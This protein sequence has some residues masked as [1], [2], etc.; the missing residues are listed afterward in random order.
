MV[1]SSMAADGA[2]AD[3]RRL[4]EWFETAPD[5]PSPRIERLT[6]RL[7]ALAVPLLGR[8][9]RGTD[10]RR[11]DAARD[12]LASL[13]R[14]SGSAERGARVRARVIDELRGVAARAAD[15]AKV[16]ALGLL[17]ELG[18]HATARFADPSAMQRRSALALAAQLDTPGDVASA[19]DLMI[20]QLGG[21]ELEQMI[22]ILVDAAPAAARRLGDEL[23]ARLD[24]SIDQRERIAG[25]VEP[26]A[27]LAPAAPAPLPRRAARPTQVAVLV[28]AAARLVVVAS[29]KAAGARRW[30]RW[31]VLVGASGRIEE[32]LHEELAVEPDE[33][34]PLIAN[35]CADG[36][37]VAS[38]ELDH[39]RAVIAKAA[40]VTAL[41]PERLMSAYYLGRDLL[42]LGD[43]HLG[44]RRRGDPTALA[45]GRAVELLAAG[46][47]A[48]AHTLLQRC[49]PRHPDV[50]GALAACLLAQGDDAG[51]IEHL[52][53]AIAAEPEWPLHH[54]NLAIA[55]QRQGDADGRYRALRRFVQA[56][57]APSGLYADPE[58]PGRVACAERMLAGLER[59]ARLAG[60]SVGSRRRARRQRP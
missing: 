42:E 7:G 12:A 26:I 59:E 53:R 21:G 47:V 4:A 24:L 38:Q 25:L 9:L 32:C 8:E 29:R 14:A 37:R 45:L 33:A 36:Y 43:A 39:A 20:R 16:C 58:Q 18:E 60:R 1:S 57:A 44:D 34:T 55:L 49:D 19:A 35:L 30:R 6:R 52:A 3:L 50:A 2:F 22:E 5:S 15:D 28:D 54:W 41:D 46:D 40:R 56:S 27:S 11:R 23:A 10:P 48:R 51:A 13:A 17:A 31:A